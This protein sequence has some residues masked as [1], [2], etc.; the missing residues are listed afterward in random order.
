M[1]SRIAQIFVGLLFMLTLAPL[2][3]PVIPYSL[4]GNWQHTPSWKRCAIQQRVCW[5]VILQA[6]IPDFYITKIKNCENGVKPILPGQC[7]MSNVLQHFVSTLMVNSEAFFKSISPNCMLGFVVH[8]LFFFFF[9]CNKLF[10]CKQKVESL[11]LICTK[12]TIYVHFQDISWLYV[13]WIV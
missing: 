4:G 10:P 13:L 8:C 1:T 12:L 6:R 11:C 7:Y 5:S 2:L 9:L 3:A